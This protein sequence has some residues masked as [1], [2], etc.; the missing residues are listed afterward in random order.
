MSHAATESAATAVQEDP[1]LVPAAR[2]VD[3]HKVYGAGDTGV[4][5]LDG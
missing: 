3:L 1:R 4:A 5:A 2:A